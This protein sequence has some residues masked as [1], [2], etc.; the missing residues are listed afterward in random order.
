MNVGMNGRWGLDARGSSQYH[1]CAL[2]AGKKAASVRRRR[3][4]KKERQS[5]KEADFHED[6]KDMLYIT[7]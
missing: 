3:E 1:L 4:K 2:D 5:E 7:F 6:A